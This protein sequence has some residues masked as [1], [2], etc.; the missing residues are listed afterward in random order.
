[1]AEKRGNAMLERIQRSWTLTKQS[2]SV[3]ASDRHLLIF[4]VLSSIACLI[5]LASFAVPFVLTGVLQSTEELGDVV[6]TPVRAALLFLFYFINFFIIT[7]FNSAL[8]ACALNR[9]NGQDSSAS[10]GFRAANARLPQIFAWSGLSATVGVVLKMLEERMGL[11]GAIVIRLIGMGWA[12]ASYFVV[13]VLVVEGVGPIE[14]VKRSAAVLKRNWGESLI[15]N[16]G[17][18]AVTSFALLL[19][20]LPFGIG[21]VGTVAL[22]S[23]IPVI[24][25]GAVTVILVIAV[26]LISSTL[27]SVIRAALYRYATT[28]EAPPQFEVSM[29]QS[30]FRE[31]GKKGK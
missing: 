29:L 24:V 2:W 30:A 1:M 5:V 3:L 25:G 16:L 6:F 23:V 21:I 15:T 14:A 27:T 9:F 22:E 20:V 12:I 28:G 8:I 10:A 4:P 7:Y 26:S 11:I 19:A 13:P 17:V 18:G 31:K